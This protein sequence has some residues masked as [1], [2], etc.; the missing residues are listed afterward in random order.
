MG[1]GHL[2][3]LGGG[4]DFESQAL[5]CFRRKN[6]CV[7]IIRAGDVAQWQCLPSMCKALGSNSSPL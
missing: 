5:S 7:S 6:G 4:G 3:L 2:S 1:W